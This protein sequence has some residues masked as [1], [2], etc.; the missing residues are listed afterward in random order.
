MS[1][2]PESRPAAAS[3]ENP[4]NV[5]CGD[6]NMRSDYSNVCNVAGTREEFLLGFG[7]RQAWQSGAKEIPNKFW[8]DSVPDY[9]LIRC[10]AMHVRLRLRERLIMTA[11]AAKRLHL[12]LAR[13]IREYKN[14]Y[15]TL[16]IEVSQQGGLAERLPTGCQTVHS[17]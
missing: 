2:S 3:G 8:R 14:R 15:G 9:A 12:L 1:G 4:L 7:V 13:V 16:P 10:R 6:S 11:Y 17:R 5:H